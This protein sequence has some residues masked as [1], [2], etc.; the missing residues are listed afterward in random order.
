MTVVDNRPNE[1]TTEVL[2]AR[3]SAE[4]G[5]VRVEQLIAA[6]RGWFAVVAP[7]DGID[8]P[9]GGATIW[10]PD[11]PPGPNQL[12]LVTAAQPTDDEIAEALSAAGRANAAAIVLRS[13]NLT[14]KAGISAAASRAGVPVLAI[15][16]NVSWE[17]ASGLVRSLASAARFGVHSATSTAG[18]LYELAESAMLALDGTVMVIDAALRVVAFACGGVVDDLTSETILTRRAPKALLDLIV[19]NGS[20]RETR[21]VDVAGARARLIAPILVGD[22]VRGH[23]VLTPGP[24]APDAAPRVLGDVAEAAAAWFLDEP[25]GSEEDTVRAELLRGLLTGTGSLEALAARVG[26][27]APGRWCLLGLGMHGTEGT[28]QTSAIGGLDAGVERLLA[29]CARMLEPG[30][31]TVVFGGVA[32]VFAPCR[33][34][35]AANR[36]AEQLRRRGATALGAPLVAC[37]SQPLATGDEVHAACGLLKQATAV[38]AA[39]HAPSTADLPELR[40]HVVIAELVDLAAEYPGLL[41]GPLDVFRGEQSPRSAEYLDTLLSWFDAGCDITKAATR[42][43]VHRNTFRYRLQR[44][45]KLCVVDLDD[46]VQ[47]FTLE[48]QVRLLVLR[49]GA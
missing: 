36:L 17:E 23:V 19:P 7:A 32:Y 49:G 10:D 4:N 38:L 2:P 26:L 35:P 28:K 44:I 47:R 30:A 9:V 5:T 40:P 13:R 41:N 31:A 24:G 27:V 6:R 22:V 43:G 46:A 16:D 20:R 29:R 1:S 37:V 8:R 48:L 12:V 42:L 33:A 39:R 34:G 45:E 25:G 3:G 21:R 15:A 11:R 14:G 18:G